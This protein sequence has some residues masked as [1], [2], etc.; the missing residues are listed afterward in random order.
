MA[1]RPKKNGCADVMMTMNTT[2]L[3]GA[4]P[5]LHCLKG[6]YAGYEVPVLPTGIL[7]GRDS[8]SC[9]L[10]FPNTPEVSRYHCRVFY[11][12]RTGYFVV[13]DLNSQNGVYREDGSRVRPGEKLALAAGQI[14]KLCGD[15]IVFRTAVKERGE[16]S[17]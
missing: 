11:D 2:A 3:P 17:G 5:F 8:G 15:L 4:Q 7:I 16:A 6:D 14:F 9:H 12:R 10:L 13:T 1:D